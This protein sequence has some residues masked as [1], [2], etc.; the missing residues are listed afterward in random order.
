MMLGFAIALGAL[1][2]AAHASSPMSASSGMVTIQTVPALPGVHF[3]L[4]GVQGVTG[5]AGSAVVSDRQLDTA[6]QDLVVPYQQLNSSLKV[7]L[8]RVV[9]DPDHPLFQRLLLVDL[10][11]DRAVNI[12]VTTPE[13][14][15][16]P[17]AEVTSVTLQDSLGRTLQLSSKDL[18]GPTWLASRRAVPDAAG[19]AARDVVYTVSSVV[20]H[21][22]NIVSAGRYHFE[23]EQTPDWK[24]PGIFFTLTV[25]GDDILGGK[26]AG[27]SLRLVYPDHVAVE[28]PLDSQH[29]ARIADLPRGD[30]SLRVRGGL[31]GLTSQV[32]LSRNQLITQV[33]IT[34]GDALVIGLAGLGAICLL[35]ATGMAG[36][37][38][39]RTRKRRMELSGV[40]A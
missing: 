5:A 19:V 7:S 27:T 15:S 39:R 24:V 31:V 28:V 2:P 6:A 17:A 23:P 9:N 38:L 26:P 10:D 1:A 22:S 16:L 3:S 18:A 21:G 32:R 40:P 13:G 4:N 34:R 36:R 33:V 29:R 35:A 25:Q 37:H 30:Y 20:V 14:V 11:E 8:D 12:V